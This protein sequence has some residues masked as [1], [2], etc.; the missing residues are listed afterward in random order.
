MRRSGVRIPSAPPSRFLRKYANFPFSVVVC[1]IS[2]GMVCWD[3]VPLLDLLLLHFAP[4]ILATDGDTVESRS[5][6]KPR[7][8]EFLT[9]SGAIQIIGPVS[10]R[11]TNRITAKLKVHREW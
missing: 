9:A 5:R 10:Q 1:L 6:D 7:S 4:G 11:S 3:R 2:T 8:L